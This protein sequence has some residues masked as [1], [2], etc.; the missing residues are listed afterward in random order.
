[1]LIFVG[2]LGGFCQLGEIKQNQSHPDCV[3]AGP[4]GLFLLWPQKKWRGKPCPSLQGEYLLRWT[5]GV[6][7]FWYVFLGGHPTSRK[8]RHPLA[9]SKASILTL[10]SFGP[11]TLT[12]LLRRIVAFL[13]K[14]SALEMVKKHVQTSI[15]VTR[16]WFEWFVFF[17]TR[18]LQE[19]IQL[20]FLNVWFNH[21][22]DINYYVYQRSLFARKK[23]TELVVHFLW[24]W[25]PDS[26]KTFSGFCIF[27]PESWRRT[28]GRGDT[29]PKTN[30]SQV[31]EFMT[32]LSL[33]GGHLTM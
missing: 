8:Q 26:Y 19:M 10:L 22:L 33:V 9:P 3:F 14:R 25:S 6:W 13:G 5:H 4:A 21:H 7:C 15:S 28:H 17:F 29:H 30:I 32:F 12:F 18:I 2:I 11:H 20:S 31:I 24:T 1:M 16:W 23:T 27:S